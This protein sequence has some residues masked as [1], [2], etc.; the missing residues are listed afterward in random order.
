LQP[1]TLQDRLDA[2]TDW[3]SPINSIWTFIT[4]IGAVLIPFIIRLY[5][6]KS[7]EKETVRNENNG[8]HDTSNTFLKG[9]A[10]IK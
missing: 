7:K 9:G 6:N 2:F 10:P 1:L 8:Q 5:S 4:A 3:L